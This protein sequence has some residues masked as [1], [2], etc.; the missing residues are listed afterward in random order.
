M[1]PEQQ[2]LH[3]QSQQESQEVRQAQEQSQKALEFATPEE[4]LRYDAAHTEVPSKVEERLKRS[5]QHESVPQRSWW[6]RLF[7]R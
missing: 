7:N 5:L 1:N 4:M 3:H 6:R 2:R